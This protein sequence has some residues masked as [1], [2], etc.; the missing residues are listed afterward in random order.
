LPNN[1]LPSIVV[2][3][4]P[5]LKSYYP[6]AWDYALDAYAI[7]QKKN[8]SKQYAH[9][10]WLRMV[11]SSFNYKV[12]N[13]HTSFIALE[14]EDQK[15][16]LLEHQDDLLA[17]RINE[18]SVNASMMSEPPLFILMILCFGAILFFKRI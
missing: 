13:H 8:I 17:G 1:N 16:Q 18:N 9:D 10:D 5:E 2:E 3:K 12:M 11:K 14:T 6:N 4:A 7:N 15:R